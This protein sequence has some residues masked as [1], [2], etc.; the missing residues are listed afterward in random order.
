MQEQ[1]WTQI[2]D[3]CCHKGTLTAQRKLGE[4]K[5]K[6]PVP[7]LVSEVARI[8]H[9]VQF[10]GLRRFLK[11]ALAEEEIRKQFRCGVTTSDDSGRMRG[12]LR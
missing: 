5:G 10:R 1:P 7:Y 11:I 3:L 4:M 8:L 12:K 9:I 6:S 2:V